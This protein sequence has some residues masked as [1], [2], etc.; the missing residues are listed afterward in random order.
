MVT[1]PDAIPWDRVVHF[2]GRGTDIPDAIRRL[3]SDAHEA[4]EEYLGD[5]LE[6]QDSLIQATPLAV[7]LMVRALNEGRVR[8]AEAVRRILERIGAAARFQVEE[9]SA[10]RRSEADWEALFAEPHLWPPFE[11]DEEDEAL[12]EEWGPSDE[13]FLG[14]HVLTLKLLEDLPPQPAQAHSE[15]DADAGEAG[16]AG[17]KPWW[18]F[19]E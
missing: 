2:H 17:R 10:G 16:A 19:W 7:R 12:W 6:H 5:H 15:P 11:S 9:A 4:A 8:D 3:N 13:Q 18:R 14:W 1:H